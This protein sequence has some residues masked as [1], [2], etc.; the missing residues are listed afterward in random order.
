MTLADAFTLELR[1]LLMGAG[2]PYPFA[3]KPIEGFGALAYRGEPL[4][5]AGA[6]GQLPPRQ[7]L[8][9]RVL[10][11]ALWLFA[12]DAGNDAEALLADLAA[13]AAPVDPDLDGDDVL[14]LTI[15]LGGDRTYLAR[16]VVTRTNSDLAYLP[17]ATPLVDVEFVA[18]DPRF[19]NAELNEA[20]APQ[21]ETTGGLDLPHGFPHGFGSATSGSLDLDNAGNFATPPVVTITAGA[22]GL[23]NPSYSLDDGVNRIDLVIELA[24][25]DELTID[26]GARTILLNGSASRATAL[27]R[28]T[29]SWFD[30]PPGV[31][32]L[33]FTASGGEGD[34]AVSWRDAWLL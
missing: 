31:S 1:G 4:D 11:W 32:S 7:L 26:H 20:T 2:T 6:H 25:G 10:R 21:A 5:R 28:S 8:S 13:A 22:G 33:S 29:S 24:E 17:Q 9:G 18:T 34:L 14:D 19:Y 23:S 15:R 12:D 16:G 30:L 3:D 27:D